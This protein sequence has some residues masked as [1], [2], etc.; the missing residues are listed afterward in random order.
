[1]DRKTAPAPFTCDVGVCRVRSLAP[2]TT[3]AGTA[4]NQSAAS[5][6]PSTSAWT[7]MA[8][9]NLTSLARAAIPAAGDPERNVR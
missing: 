6:A 8:H 4:A 3:M 5:S 1:M 9:S 7:V 2:A